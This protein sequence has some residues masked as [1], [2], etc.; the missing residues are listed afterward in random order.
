[1]LYLGG[2]IF[3]CRHCYQLAYKCQRET[4]GDRGYRGA[5]KVRKKL[6]WQPGIVN[7]PGDKPK[8]M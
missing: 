6:V 4:I 7:P 5:G 1:V 2:K 8:G 3:A